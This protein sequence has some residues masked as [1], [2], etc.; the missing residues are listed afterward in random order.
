MCL[1]PI[2]ETC[3]DIKVA[4]ETNTYTKNIGTISKNI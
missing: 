3:F 4:K 1:T 2:S